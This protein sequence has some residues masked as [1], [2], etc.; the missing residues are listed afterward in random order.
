M[1]KFAIYG[2]Y[3]GGNYPGGDEKKFKPVQKG[4]SYCPNHQFM[5]FDIKISTS[6][7]NFWVDATDIG[8][9]LKDNVR[10]IPIYA[11]GS[12]EEIF[13]METKMDSTIP[14]VLG[15]EKVNQNIVEGFVLRP[16]KTIFFKDH[17]RVMLKKKN[18]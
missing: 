8:R 9:I 18:A 16:N 4:I 17:S 15:F 1:I 5:A 10:H 12:F 7:I 11:Q 3:F 6:E 13:A 2:E 14:E